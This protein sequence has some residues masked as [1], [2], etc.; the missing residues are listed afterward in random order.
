MEKNNH[1]KVYFPLNDGDFRFA[2]HVSLLESILSVMAILKLGGI[3]SPD[4]YTTWIQFGWDPN[5]KNDP[6]KKTIFGSQLGGESRRAS[7]FK[8]TYLG[9]LL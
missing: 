9:N 7:Y 1:L 3:Q 8:Y 5:L 2:C 4:F 6:K